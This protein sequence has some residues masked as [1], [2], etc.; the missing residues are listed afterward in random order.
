MYIY[1]LDGTLSLVSIST[2]FFF[3]TRYCSQRDFPRGST[4]SFFILL[5]RTSFILIEVYV[6]AI[7]S[8]HLRRLP[9]CHPQM[10]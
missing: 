8:S 9:L 10:V 7:N 6:G 2:V 5:A 4:E 1:T 3:I